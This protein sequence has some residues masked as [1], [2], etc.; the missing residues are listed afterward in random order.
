MGDPEPTPATTS[1][2]VEQKAKMSRVL[3]WRNSFGS[4]VAE[5]E[6]GEFRLCLY[7]TLGILPCPFLAVLHIPRPMTLVP[8]EFS[9][10]RFAHRLRTCPYP[11]SVFSHAVFFLAVLMS[12][13]RKYSH[14]P[15]DGA[16]GEIQSQQGSDAVSPSPDDFPP[17][18]ASPPHLFHAPLTIKPFPPPSR[19]LATIPNPFRL[20]LTTMFDGCADIAS[21]VIFM[22]FPTG[23]SFSNVIKKLETVEDWLII[24]ILLVVFTLTAATN[25]TTTTRTCSHAYLLC[26]RCV[27]PG[28]G[29]A[30]APFWVRSRS[31]QDRRSV[32]LR[33]MSPS[34]SSLFSTFPFCRHFFPSPSRSRHFALAPGKQRPSDFRMAP[35]Y[36]L[37]PLGS[38]IYHHIDTSLISPPTTFPR[39]SCVSPPITPP[40]ASCMAP[41]RHFF[42]PPVK[43]GSSRQRTT[44]IS[45][46][47]SH[48]RP[49]Q[50]A[51]ERIIM[52]PRLLGS[53]PVHRRS[54]R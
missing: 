7:R 10:I 40:H 25:A 46:S 24:L 34:F 50:D 31:L 23:L 37:Q 6:A 29:G 11:S 35:I 39:S 36:P 16:T 8:C 1:A 43:P 2:P 41:T 20:W 14:E 51:F 28:P 45:L 3:A 21:G 32:R 38:G 33:M 47:H 49:I 18:P 12:L 4:V 17:F 42:T 26:L 48:M 54:V 13:K 19:V 22:R 5:D 52:F 15:D 30:P 27:V 44:C 9:R 53:S